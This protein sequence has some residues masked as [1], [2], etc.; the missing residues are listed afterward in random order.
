MTTEGV[1]GREPGYD[2]LLT[3]YVDAL[4]DG[5]KIDSDAIHAAHPEHADQL[6]RD[7]AT[8]VDPGDGEDGSGISDFRTLGDYELRGQ[9]GRGGMGVV[10]DA[11]QNSVDRR[12]ALKV[13]PQALAADRKACGRFLREAQAAGRLSH[14]AV[15]SVY[16]LGV[17]DGVPYYSM[18]SACQP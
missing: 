16:S 9:I 10:Y 7:L 1:T 3:Q 2:E 6:L 8:F 12:V 4:V 17:E 15:V 13:L 5:E 11:W 14:P 18:E